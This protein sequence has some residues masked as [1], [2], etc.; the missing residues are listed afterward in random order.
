[1]GKIVVV[2]DNDGDV[3]CVLK[4][5]SISSARK[6]FRKYLKYNTSYQSE[7]D[8]DFEYKLVDLI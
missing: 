3:S 1:M 5:S 7:D 2:L 6:K 8:S 4:A